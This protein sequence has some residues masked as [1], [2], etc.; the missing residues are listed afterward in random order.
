[1]TA[2]RLSVEGLRKSYGKK[3][4]LRGLYLDAL[5]GT[6]TAVLG[7][8]GCG[9]T[10]FMRCLL[11]LHVPDDGVIRVL[12]EDTRSGPAYR[13]HIGYM[14]QVPGFPE[15][16][17]VREIAR[18][19]EKVRGSS[20]DFS[21]GETLGIRDFLGQKWKTLSG[22]MKQKVN[23]ALA[24]AFDAPLLVLD[25][26]TASLDPASRLHLMD[27]LKE[28]KARGKTILI[29]TH[30]LDDLWELADRLA[31]LRDGRAHCMDAGDMPGMGTDPALF[32]RHV[33]A[34]LEDGRRPVNGSL[35]G[36][37]KPHPAEVIA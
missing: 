33:A 15:N 12:G 27:A 23:A 36:T 11:G 21:R 19:V 37:R 30:R 8:N 35:N 1:M 22:G 16:L 20:P 5:P 10:T 17:T 32:E 28:E 9:K 6:V 7:P 2:A 4:V 14:P 24:L 29:T 18:L 34:H 26:P 25:E 3:N 13:R 31:F